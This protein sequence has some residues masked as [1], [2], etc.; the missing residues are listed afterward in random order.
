MPGMSSGPRNFVAFESDLDGMSSQ[1]MQEHY[2]VNRSW[3][4][5]RPRGAEDSG[6]RE[7]EPAGARA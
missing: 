7:P 5:P 6:A 1:T 4:E 3:S 2:H